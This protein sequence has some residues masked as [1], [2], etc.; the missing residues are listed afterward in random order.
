MIMSRSYVC[1]V[2]SLNESQEGVPQW[3]LDVEKMNR[4]YFQRLA[5]IPALFRNLII[6]SSVLHRDIQQRRRLR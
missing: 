3:P 1:I 5:N 6:F 2:S 4:T